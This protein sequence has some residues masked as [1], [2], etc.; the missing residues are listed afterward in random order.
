MHGDKEFMISNFSLILFAFFIC[1]K[2]KHN[3]NM[4]PKQLLIKPNPG[5]CVCVCVCVFACVFVTRKRT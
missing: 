1:T 3:T 2:T 4:L 5:V